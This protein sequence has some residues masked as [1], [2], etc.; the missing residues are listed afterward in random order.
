[1]SANP[2]NYENMVNGYTLKLFK[3][4]AVTLLTRAATAKILELSKYLQFITLAPVL[5]TRQRHYSSLYF[6]ECN[7]LLV[8]FYITDVTLRTRSLFGKTYST[9]H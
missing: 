5:S 2:R 8:I 9:K 3:L 4:K 7:E 6:K 1:M